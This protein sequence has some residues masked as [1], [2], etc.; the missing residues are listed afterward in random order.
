MRKLLERIRKFISTHPYVSAWL[1]GYCY[2]G[3]LTSW[4]Y[5]IKTAELA[6]G[7]GV[8]VVAVSAVILTT[9]AFST[10]F[11]LFVWA[12]R[13]L[14]LTTQNPIIVLQVALLWPLT[15]YLRA[16]IFSIFFSG[17]GSSIGPYWTNGDIGYWLARTPLVFA[18]RWGG[19][20]LL[21]G[22]LA[23]SIMALYNATRR[24]YYLGLTIMTILVIACCLSGWLIWR[25]AEGRSITVTAAHF[26]ELND[27]AKTSQLFEQAV[28][29]SHLEPAD[30][31]VLP[32][33]SSVWVYDAGRDTATVR[34]LVKNTGVVIDSSRE[35]TKRA[36]GHN[37]LTFHRADGTVLREQ[38]KQL[39]IPGGEYI[40]YAYQALLA[41]T[42]KD[43]LIKNFRNQRS[44]EQGS[45]VEEPFALNGISYGSYAC[46][47][48]LAP[49]PYRHMANDG[50]TILTNSA[51]LGTL[52]VGK[53]YHE[54]ATI[55]SRLHAVSNAR[56]FVQAARGGPT[57]IIDHNGRVKDYQ[58]LG[59]F[60][61]VSSR[62]ATN[63]KKTMYTIT[64]DWVVWLGAIYVVTKLAILLTK[65][66]Q[67]NTLSVRSTKNA[68][69][70]NKSKIKKRKST[71][72][73]T[74]KQ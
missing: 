73:K 38:A 30:A 74:D 16:I 48:I 15:E 50:A 19:L 5:S 3:V 42:G 29:R 52:G 65:K 6:D 35:N 18:S 14:R 57:Y 66:N 17:P 54:Q 33:Y 49:M 4:M 11:V 9:G 20:Y 41:Y 63:T 32:E 8:Q 31:L 58:G 59:G 67:N 21:S 24:K 68:K 39:L 55:M 46:S 26:T 22:L 28:N 1:V 10:S 43:S 47:A 7:A 44:V 72:A 37:L 70:N 36:L 2:F 69:A 40:P 23:G 27:S 13:K 25:H 12:W 53:L 45:A 56:P 34:K 60:E 61:F 51:S 62:V 64:G 71:T